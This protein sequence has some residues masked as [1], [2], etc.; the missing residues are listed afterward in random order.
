MRQRQ[1]LVTWEIALLALTLLVPVVWLGL[2]MMKHAIQFQEVRA[3]IRHHDAAGLGR[4][5]RQV[6]ADHVVFQGYPLGLGHLS[7]PNALGEA[8][9]L[10]DRDLV[11]VFHATARGR[12]TADYIA[13][14]IYYHEISP[15]ARLCP[16][17]G[18]E[19]RSW[20]REEGQAR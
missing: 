1:H 15:S 13:N 12:L 4:L 20:L 2:P 10:C 14:A 18:E 11:D 16:Q 17:I 3:L 7:I 8:A 5:L 19:M 6:G 9:L